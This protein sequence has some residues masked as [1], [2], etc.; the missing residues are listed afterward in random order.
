MSIGGG[1]NHLRNRAALA[2]KLKARPFV[3]SAGMPR[4]G[5]TLLF[6]MLREIMEAR[7]GTDLRSCWQAEL[8]SIASGRAY[9]VKTHLLYGFYRW[10][11]NHSFYSYRDIRTAAVSRI[12]KKR[13]VLDIHFFRKHIAQYELAKRHCNLCFSYEDLTE[14][15]DATVAQLASKLGIAVEPEKILSRLDALTLPEEGVRYC[16]RTLLHPNHITNTGAEEWREVLPAS[17][18]REIHE[19]FGWW[20]KECGYP[21]E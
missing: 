15:K 9:L 10:R 21:T 19:E 13:Q 5:S 17:L 18:Q 2:W 4:S 3:V 6:N 11:A 20:F 8:A 7:W 1:I 12:K 16:Q 14:S